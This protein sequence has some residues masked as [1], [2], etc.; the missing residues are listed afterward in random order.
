VTE[1]WVVDVSCSSAVGML[2]RVAG[3]G[4]TVELEWEDLLVEMGVVEKLASR[5]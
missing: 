2:E 3:V 4:G 1:P 5:D